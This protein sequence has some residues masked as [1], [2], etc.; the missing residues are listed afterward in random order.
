MNDGIL[1]RRYFSAVMAES[2]GIPS[3]SHPSIALTWKS[4]NTSTRHFLDDRKIW[5]P[6]VAMNSPM[7]CNRFSGLLS[8]TSAVLWWNVKF[9]PKFPCTAS[10]SCCK[11]FTCRG[12]RHEDVRTTMQLS[13][14]V[15]MICAKRSTILSQTPISELVNSAYV[16]PSPCPTSF[17]YMD[18]IF[19]TMSGTATSWDAPRIRRAFCTFTSLKLT[20][21][22]PGSSIPTLSTPSTST[23]RIVSMDPSS[24]G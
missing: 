18:R 14:A 15:L 20:D 24:C 9:L 10:S 19:S 7:V 23:K 1:F 6:L 17:S 8:W 11:S 5:L 2:I 21:F 13:P 12:C 4:S 16:D 22:F 3:Q